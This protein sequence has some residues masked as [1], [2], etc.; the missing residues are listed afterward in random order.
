MKKVNQF[1]RRWSTALVLAALAYTSSAQAWIE[2]EVEPNS[3]THTYDFDLETMDIS[4]NVV[5]GTISKSWDLGGNFGV[6]EYC[7]QRINDAR[8]YSTTSTMTPSTSNPGYYRLNEYFD[9]KVEVWIA[10]NRSEYVT[11]PFTD[12]TNRYSEA[13]KP[14]SSRFNNVRSGSKGK[15][16]FR[17]T[18][19]VINGI[20]LVD[21]ELVKVFG[22]RGLL[23]AGV[24]SGEALST[25]NIRSG[26]I[27]VPD[28]C[29]I[30]QGTPISV[31]F[32]AIPNTSEKLNGNNYVQQ[33]PIQVQCKGGSFDTGYL[34]IKMGIQS[35][36]SGVAS[37]N[38][39][40]L[41][42]NGANDRRDLGIVIK[43][44][45]G[46]T[47]VPNQFYDV[48]GFNN[49]QGVWNLTAAPIAKPGSI[50][51]EGEFDAAA[52]VVAQFQ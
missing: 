47:V 48:P 24:L 40:Y 52:T 46:S 45:S 8:Y 10:G 20:V 32:G 27:T 51:P 35:A 11:S 36:G 7:T 6:T 15:I 5:G 43:D 28:K 23:S 31:E 44:S 42:T 13:C 30:N 29:I 4:N 37:F 3:G 2:G 22:R 19:P 1:S 17:V 39:D 49:N 33:V 34:N 26:I 41:G 50:I 25:I 12:E 38:S 18:K 16:T 21:H 14:P 9:V